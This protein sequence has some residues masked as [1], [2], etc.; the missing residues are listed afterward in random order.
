MTLAPSVTAVPSI[1]AAPINLAAPN[2]SPPLS[3]PGAPSRQPHSL[4]M[5]VGATGGTGA[6]CFAA[7]FAHLLH[8][9]GQPSVLIDLDTRGPGI[10]VLLG[11]ESEP[12]AR[13][14]ELGSARGVVDGRG[15]LASLPQWRDVPVV[16]ASR[17]SPQ[18]VPDSIVLDVVAALLHAGC[19]VVIDAPRATA[20]TPAIRALITDADALFL[21]AAATLPGAA[22]AVALAHEMQALDS[23]QRCSL[24]VREP[25]PGFVDAEDI[26][27]LTGIT[28]AAS[29]RDDR[30]I[31]LAVERGEGPPCGARTRLGRAAQAALDAV[32]WSG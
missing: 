24:V 31:T 10:D 12:G 22:G 14:P 18:H 4:A 7:A 11:I 32:R 16:S 17:T 25:G 15:L 29:I 2:T 27:A 6:S 9:Q 8:R 20:W 1:S 19:R 5:T 28:V 3:A 21:V 30:K 26:E 13:W 23:G